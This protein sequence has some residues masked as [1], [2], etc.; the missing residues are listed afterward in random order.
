VHD[1]VR[2][3]AAWALERTLCSNAS[4]GTFL[5]SAMLRCDERDHAL[6]YELVL[7]TL[8]WLR[9]I[10]HVIASAANRPLDR[11][12]PALYAPLRLGVYQLMFLDRV[13]A[14]A[15][16]HEAVAHALRI[17][18]RGGGN[19][20]NAV[21]RRIS[22]SPRLGSWPVEDVDPIRRLAVESSH[23]DFLV[24]RWLDRF[25]EA[26]T[27]EILEAN[28]RDKPFHLLAFRDRGGRE[29][30]AEQ[31]IDEGLEV[32]PSTL[33]PLGLKVRGGRPWRSPVF[34]QGEIYIQDE[35]SQAAALVPLPR[36]GERILDL[37]ASP[38]GKTFSALAYDPTIRPV[39]ADISISRMLR[40]RS[41]LHRLRRQLPLVVADGAAP[42]FVDRFARV[43]VDLP[44]S[45]T[46]TLRRK[47]ELR[48]RITEKEIERLAREG[49]ALLEGAATSVEPGGLLVAITCSIEREENEEV[50]QKL[51]QRRADL[52]PVE[53]GGSVPPPLELG[54][55]PGG[56]WR[57]LPG[58][59]H[60]GFT[61][62]VLRRSI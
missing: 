32:E 45:G 16:V 9:R 22:R 4:A 54:L 1:N 30:I 5:T 34:E 44:C 50:V 7:G 14:H 51:L 59:D 26:A 20:V 27:R 18:H 19:F 15:V 2:E 40:L 36:A 49:L 28:N 17:T 60:D 48:W 24:R 62:Q 55:L 21:L 35:A 10:D 13:P 43:V 61:V 58:D 6:L 47:P 31:L 57:L 42:P 12:E 8:R 33:S 3:A 29:L 37:A 38:G 25:G 46:G 11:I 52:V 39:A 56:L 41:N 23:P 53:L